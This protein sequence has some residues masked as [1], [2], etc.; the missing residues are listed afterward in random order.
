MTAT[1]EC[2]EESGI[3]DTFF[4]HQAVDAGRGKLAIASLDSIHSFDTAGDWAAS[5]HKCMHKCTCPPKPRAGQ[6]EEQHARGGGQAQEGWNAVESHTRRRFCHRLQIGGTDLPSGKN[7]R[8]LG[9]SV[10]NRFPR[11]ELARSASRAA[12][13]ARSA[14]AQRTRAAL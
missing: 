10:P 8:I 4:S 2:C 11:W 1:N 13:L 12:G 3:L 14:I 7:D 9:T 6:S 5:R